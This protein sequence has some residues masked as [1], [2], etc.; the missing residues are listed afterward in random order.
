MR[1]WLDLKGLQDW[2]N[3]A[4]TDGVKID[5]RSSARGFNTLRASA[6]LPFNIMDIF[7]TMMD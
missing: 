1:E 2:T 3:Q 7:V 6:V 4:N 5:Y